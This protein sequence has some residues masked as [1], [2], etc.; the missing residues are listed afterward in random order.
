MRLP[1]ILIFFV[2]IFTSCSQQTNDPIQKIDE[3][4]KIEIRSLRNDLE[5]FKGY[6]TNVESQDGK[7][8]P[9]NLTP[10]LINLRNEKITDISI[11]SLQKIINGYNLVFNI[12][13]S[14]YNVLLVSTLDAN[15]SIIDYKIYP[16]GTG[17]SDPEKDT[18]SVITYDKNEII[19]QLMHPNLE[20]EPDF[21][22]NGIKQVA[23]TI[24]NDLRFK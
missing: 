15:Y 4:T 14:G 24:G 12:D 23:L 20:E 17:N 3:E 5:K 9:A 22:L 6:Y 11:N 16:N 18:I 2:V 19:I 13:F 8:T 1:F 10:E 7:I 21:N